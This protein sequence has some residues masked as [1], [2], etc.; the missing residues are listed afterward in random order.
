MEGLKQ[1]LNQNNPVESTTGN[2]V[3]KALVDALKKSGMSFGPAGTAL[4]AAVS[5]LTGP[6]GKKIVATLIFV[7]MFLS[8]LAE[9]LPSI[10]FNTIFHT[11]TNHS[12]TPTIQEEIEKEFKDMS[13]VMAQEAAVAEVVR[14]NLKD[15]YNDALK[16]IPVMCL[17]MGVEIDLSRSHLVDNTKTPGVVEVS[18]DQSGETIDGDAFLSL[19]DNDYNLYAIL[20]SYSVSVDQLKPKKDEKGFHLFQLFEQEKDSRS[21]ITAKISKYYK[22]EILG[23]H[24]NNVYRVSYV[25]EENG[26]KPRIFDDPEVTTNEDGSTSVKHHYYIKPIIHNFDVQSLCEGSFGIKFSDRY[27]GHSENTTVAQAVTTMTNAYLSIMNKGPVSGNVLGVDTVPGG[28]TQ[29]YVFSLQNPTMALYPGSFVSPFDVNWRQVRISSYMTTRLDPFGSGKLEGHRGV[30][31][32]MPT[33]SN[34]NAIKGGKVIYVKYSTSTKGMGY[35]LAIDHGGGIASIYAHC[36]LILVNAGDDVI[37][38]QTIAKVGST[39]RSTGPHLHL[40]MIKNGQN[41]NPL[42]YLQN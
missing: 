9:S 18:Q 7:M 27:A 29:K 12:P 31:F 25:G 1:E 2:I 6:A 38:G 17:Q 19:P 33:G 26:G 39:G 13:V 36:S 23:T 16:T 42:T 35:H 15:A 28:S 20:S 10:M 4:S 41:V 14:S 11:N 5:V 34:I 37:A 30:D 40:E 21:D 24:G 32:P 8:V 22:Q 3:K